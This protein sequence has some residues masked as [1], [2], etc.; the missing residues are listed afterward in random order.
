MADI[1]HTFG[2]DLTLSS[3]G[4][5]AIVDSTQ[6]GQERV[7]RRLLTNP[8]DYIWLLNYGAGLRRFVGEVI[9]ESRIKAVTRAQMFRE[10]SVTRNP[11]PVVEVFQTGNNSVVMDILYNDAETNTA[12]SLYFPVNG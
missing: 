7:L 4:D 6:R 3:T 12:Q 11:A 8:G 10:A 2:N 9:N 1:Q 5:I